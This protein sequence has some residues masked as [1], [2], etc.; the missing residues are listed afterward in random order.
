MANH[1]TDTVEKILGRKPST[2]EDFVQDHKEVWMK[3]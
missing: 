1:I 3:A 2:I